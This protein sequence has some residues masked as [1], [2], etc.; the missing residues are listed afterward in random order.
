M[1]PYSTVK[2]LLWGEL[3][4]FSRYSG[5]GAICGNFPE[6]PKSCTGKHERL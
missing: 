6:Y 1:R 4:L 5:I 3:Y 2:V